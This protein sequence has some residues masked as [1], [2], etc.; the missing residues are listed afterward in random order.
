MNNRLDARI[1]VARGELIVGTLVVPMT[2]DGAG[3]D[4]RV[5]GATGPVLRPLR[6]GERTRLSSLAVTSTEPQASLAAAI[7]RASTVTDGV[8]DATV[9]EVAALL[10]SGARHPGESFGAVLLRVGRAG[11]WGL[12]QIADAPADEVDRLGR[13]LH[14]GQVR[15]KADLTTD[16]AI[17]TVP[18]RDDGG[19]HSWGP[20]SADAN[21]VDDDG[22][23]RLV[24][25]DGGG[26][27]SVA[28]VRDMLADNL[29]A[30]VEDAGPNEAQVDDAS[31]TGVRG[32]QP[33]DLQSPPDVEPGA[34]VSAQWFTRASQP[35]LP[36]SAG[37]GQVR[38][39]AAPTARIESQSHPLVRARSWVPASGGADMVHRTSESTADV[40]GS[41]Q[42]WVEARPGVPAHSP[43]PLHTRVPAHSWVPASAGTGQARLG[44]TPTT[45]AERRD[46]SRGPR[47]S[48]PDLLGLGAVNRWR[49]SQPVSSGPSFAWTSGS[50]RAMPAQPREPALEPRS[51][52]ALTPDLADALAALLQDEADLRGLE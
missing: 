27:A 40:T 4:W 19:R 3:G 17:G 9:R 34:P 48:R 31:D 37:A 2:P 28:A 7:A 20:A 6:F 24:F 14:A 45:H 10:L 26:A 41:P 36:V 18:D 43:V 51:M 33:T 39:N 22:W 25:D 23:N 8:V 46:P 32:V 21:A 35:G 42:P 12:D 5:G 11:G 47:T 13:L 44:G 52:D 1:E 30:R 29:L 50:L 16:V 49:G 38:L 15:P